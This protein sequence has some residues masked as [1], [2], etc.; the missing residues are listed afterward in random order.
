MARRIIFNG[1]DDAETRAKMAGEI[2]RQTFLVEQAQRNNGLFQDAHV[3]PVGVRR[4]GNDM[5]VTA[6]VA[7]EAAPSVAPEAVRASMPQSE[8]GAPVYPAA[9]TAHSLL[10]KYPAVS[11]YTV[12]FKATYWTLTWKS[13]DNFFPDFT[14]EYWADINTGT[15]TVGELTAIL[16][17]A[18]FGKSSWSEPG[19]FTQEILSYTGPH[20]VTNQGAFTDLPGRDANYMAPITNGIYMHTHHDG[21]GDGFSYDFFPYPCNPGIIP[22]LFR[23]PYVFAGTFTEDAGQVAESIY[24]VVEGTLMDLYSNKWRTR[25]PHVRAKKDDEVGFWIAYKSANPITFWWYF[26]GNEDA[27]AYADEIPLAASDE[28]T[29]QKMSGPTV[30]GDFF[31]VAA[32]EFGVYG[33]LSGLELYVGAAFVRRKKVECFDNG[34]NPKQTTYDTRT[35]PI[36]AQDKSV[37]KLLRDGNIGPGA[38]QP[39]FHAATLEVSRK[40][41]QIN[42]L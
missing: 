2:R 38:G 28:F 17:A 16:E 15:L 8:P 5:N 14:W 4:V 11:K 23:T 26:Y 12:D 34:G 42:L 10:L 36:V 24:V 6:N 19:R 9:D 40:H 32:I 27:S 3:G 1:R 7:P 30:D 29:F 13:T 20:T 33:N 39:S 35:S 21:F 22:N 31:T 41:K 37:W 18:K 25:P